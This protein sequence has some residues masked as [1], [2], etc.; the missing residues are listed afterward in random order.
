MCLEHNIDWN[1][2]IPNE[3]IPDQG[4]NIPILPPNPNIRQNLAGQQARENIVNLYF[5]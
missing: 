1:G 3:N 5:Q 4:N 2:D